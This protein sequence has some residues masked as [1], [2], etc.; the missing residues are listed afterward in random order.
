MDVT[1]VAGLVDQIYCGPVLIVV[2]LPGRAVVI[3][4]NGIPDIVK[5]GLGIL[6]E[7]SASAA[8]VSGILSRLAARKADYLELRQG[9]RQA[10]Y[11]ASWP[12]AAAE[13]CSTLFE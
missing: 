7:P 13:L 9:A 11:H 3:L 12:R 2:S 4:C 10:Q 1:N 6:V 5:P 8:E